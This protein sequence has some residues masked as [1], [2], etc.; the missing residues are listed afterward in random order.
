[1]I[2]QNSQLLNPGLCRHYVT[3]QQNT[4]THDADGS[5][6]DSWSTYQTAHVAIS[7]TGG[8]EFQQAK[9]VNSTLTH[10]VKMQYLDGIRPSMRLLWGSRVLL[11]HAVLHDEG[12]RRWTVLQCEEINQ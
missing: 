2:R 12:I 9:Q 11:I 4:P 10:E 1:M 3:I 5:L 8:R 6:I 7:T